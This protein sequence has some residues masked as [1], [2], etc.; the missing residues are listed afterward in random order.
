MKIFIFSFLV[1]ISRF[2]FASENSVHCHSLIEGGAVVAQTNLRVFE[3]NEL[4]SFAANDEL[5][6]FQQA[7]EAQ[8]NIIDPFMIQDDEVK[9]NATLFP[10]YAK[11]A[12]I[13][14]NGT[15]GFI[16]PVDLIE[17]GLLSFHLK[18]VSHCHLVEFQALQF[19]NSD[20]LIKILYQTEGQISVSKSEDFKNTLEALVKDGYQVQSHIHNHPFFPPNLNLGNGGML[21]PSGD[22]A[23]GDVGT[24]RNYILK[25]GMKEANVTNGF[26]TVVLSASEIQKL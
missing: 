22:H 19:V 21:H 2:G 9:R 14:R 10:P 4:V 8:G 6:K 7:I 13:I 25:F 12:E 20:G 24:Y 15:L 16:R 11:R 18:N 23:F 5:A 1:A 17:R 26:H 3:S